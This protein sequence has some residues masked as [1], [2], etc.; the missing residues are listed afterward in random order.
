MN[1]YDTERMM[2]M[3]TVIGS[4]RLFMRLQPFLSRIIWRKVPRRPM[5]SLRPKALI[6]RRRSDY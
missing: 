2:K 6:H 3:I 1:P 4:L 5:T